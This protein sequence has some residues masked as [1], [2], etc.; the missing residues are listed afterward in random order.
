WRQFGRASW[1]LG[2]QG[3]RV[4][5]PAEMLQRRIVHYTFIEEALK[6]QTASGQQIG[7]QELLKQSA[8][9]VE[10]SDG[11]PITIWTTAPTVRDGKVFS[12]IHQQGVALALHFDASL[13][14]MLRTRFLASLIQA[15]AEAAPD[16]HLVKYGLKR[17]PAVLRQ[18]LLL[19]SGSSARFW[20]AILD[21]SNCSLA[22]R[23]GKV[24]TEGA[25][26]FKSFETSHALEKAYQEAI[27]KKR[28]EG[29]LE[30]GFLSKE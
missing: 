18:R 29:Y 16:L 7:F 24:G 23:T 11:V 21:K 4:L 9:L 25:C 26:S 20:E 3:M 27:E 12:H 17:D 13:I 8:V 5:G 19:N 30:V 10:T 22:I 14:W 28:H 15:I 2:Q 6:H 1:H